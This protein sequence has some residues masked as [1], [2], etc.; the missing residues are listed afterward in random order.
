MMRSRSR[1]R[2]RRREPSSSS[3]SSSSREAKKR[4]KKSAGFDSMVKPRV[5]PPARPQDQ[6]GLNVGI[7]KRVD[8]F[9]LKGAAQYNGCEGRIV[10]GPNEK[11]R[12]EVQ[13]EF[14][15][16]VK[17]LS[18]QPENLQVKPTCGWELVVAP[19]GLGATENDINELFSKFGKVRVVNMTRDDHG[20]SKGVCLAEMVL[21]EGAEAVMQHLQGYELR[22]RQLKIDWSTKVKTEMGL[23]KT[24]GDG[25]DEANAPPR[26]RFEETHHPAGFGIGQLVTVSGL[27]GAPQFNGRVGKIISF[28]DA[29]RCEVELE[30]EPG[31]LKTLALKYENLTAAPANSESLKQAEPEPAEAAET[32]NPAPAADN[33]E[34]RAGGRR[35]FSE[36]SAKPEEAATDAPAQSQSTDEAPKARK[37]ASHWDRENSG[38]SGPAVVD[39]NQPKAPPATSSAADKSTPAAG[40]ET[41]PP[42]PELSNLPAKE[43]RRLLV[44]LG[45]DIT[46]CLEKSELL[47]KARSLA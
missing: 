24:R 35:R 23:L 45:V 18:L 29:E 14:Q 11:F 33:G 34:S 8:L 4:L 19:I 1:S 26:R 28:R 37:R 40:A 6:K 9:G 3:S 21:K 43:L 42:E 12:W 47:A 7:G 27:K 10:S 5:Q 46:G 41:L 16:E 30:Q 39:P 22:G 36:S 13:V 38:G 31:V 44:A 2:S 17:T 15:G 32:P 20:N 25:D